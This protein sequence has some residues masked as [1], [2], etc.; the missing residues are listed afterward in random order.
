MHPHTFTPTLVPKPLQSKTT[1]KTNLAEMSN[2]QLRGTPQPLVLDVGEVDRPGV[3]EVVEDV[4]RLLGG[5]APLLVPED[6]VD[7]VVKVLGHV[8]RLVTPSGRFGW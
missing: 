8:V 2:L 4:V 3:C 5:G 6:E 7:P 1:P